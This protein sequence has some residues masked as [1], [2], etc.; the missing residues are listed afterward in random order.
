MVISK[1]KRRQVSNEKYVDALQD[2][3]SKLCVVRVDFGYK[4]DENNEVNV[5]LEE[6]NKHIDKLLNNRRNNSIFKDNVGYVIKTEYT[7]D[8]GVHNHAV[9]FFDGNKV[10]NDKYKGDQ[11]GNYWETLTNGNGSYHNCNRN[12]Y[13]DNAIGM[14]DYKNVEMRKNLDNAMAYL[15]KEEQSIKAIK[16]NEKDRAIRRGTMPKSKGNV[17][18]PRIS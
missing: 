18:R 10:Q 4:K 12:D 5:T 3:Y 2:R 1:D 13:K 11:I 8:K 9:L 15:V 14:L 6:A 7:E 17:G 16:E